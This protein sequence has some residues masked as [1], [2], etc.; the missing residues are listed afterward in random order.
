MATLTVVKLATPGGADQAR[1]LMEG[2]QQQSLVRIQ[3]AAVVSWESGEK[4]P[5]TRQLRNLTGASAL[6]GSFWGLLF[7]LIFF[8][9][10]LEAVVGAAIGALQGSLIDVGIN[11]SF[12]KK[13]RN[14]VIEARPRS[15]R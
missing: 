1:T 7:G 9:S 11:D 3:D 14:E 4:K 2:L 12:I 15:S 6:N 10:L 13:V 8:V 5:K